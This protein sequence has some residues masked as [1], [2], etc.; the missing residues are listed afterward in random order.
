[1]FRYS[2]AIVCRVPDSFARISG[3]HAPI[4]VQRA[5]DEHLNYVTTLRECGVDVFE[6]SADNDLPDCPFV[7]DTCVI[8]GSTALLL[9]PG[10]PSRRKNVSAMKQ[11]LQSEFPKLRLMEVTDQHANVE[12]SDILF[13]GL[14]IFVGISNKT[15]EAGAL[16]VAS[17]F[18]DFAVTPIKTGKAFHLKQAISVAGPQILAVGASDDSQ[19]ILK[20]IE[21]ESTYRYQTVTVPD[22]EAANCLFI[23]GSLVHRLEYPDSGK[24]LEESV[25]FE[26]FPI[27][28]LEFAKANGHLSCGTVLLGKSAITGV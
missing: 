17:A 10:H 20:R 15:N 8:I 6:M 3:A 4:D 13:T 5:R 24:V 7:E 25:P 19:A 12:G 1:M 26:R 23:N 9:R 28:F 22:D 11:L 21:R 16:A 2:H 18:P 27:P 14:E